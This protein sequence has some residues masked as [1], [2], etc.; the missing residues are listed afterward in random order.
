ML[1]SKFDAWCNAATAKIRYWG[2]RDAVSAELRAHL[3]DRYDALVEAGYSHAE[4]TAKALEAMGDAKTIAPQLGKIHRPWLG[5]LLSIVRIVGLTALVG[6]L[7][8]GWYAGWDAFVSW[9][10]SEKQ[11]ADLCSLVY[12][13]NDITYYDAP[14]VRDT[15]EGFDFCVREV[16][17]V[18]LDPRFNETQ[19]HVMLEVSWWPWSQGFSQTDY[20][21]AVDSQGNYYKPDALSAINEQG[22]SRLMVWG[23]Y[24]RGAWKMSYQVQVSHFDPDAKWIELRYDRDGREMTLHIDLTGG[25]AG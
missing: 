7:V 4:A 2:D 5:W 14:N 22:V 21:W 1:N 11:E 19:L 3:E 15:M 10:V 13:A 6:A 25:G 23:G 9:Y 20:I 17:L 8:F 18:P 16:A 24:N 12:D